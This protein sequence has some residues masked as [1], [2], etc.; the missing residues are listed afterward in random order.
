MSPIVTSD[1]CFGSCDSSTVTSLL[2]KRF[3]ARLLFFFIDFNPS[4]LFLFLLSNSMCSLAL[5]F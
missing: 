2:I 5:V 1:V 3:L 4:F